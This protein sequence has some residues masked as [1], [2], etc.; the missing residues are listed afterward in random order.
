MRSLI[1]TLLAVSTLLI[2]CLTSANARVRNDGG[3][4]PAT[5]RH[6]INPFWF[7]DDIKPTRKFARKFQRRHHQR[8]DSHRSTR[9]RHASGGDSRTAT[10]VEHPAG[11]PSRSFCGCGA[12]IEVFGRNIRELWLAANWFKFPPASPAPGMVAVRRHHV[13]VIREVLS[14]GR[15]LAYDANSGGHRTRIWIRSLAG[16]SVRNPRGGSHDYARA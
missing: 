2:C 13:F 14:G 15:V 4:Q 5:D 12:S 16:F 10:F 3:L 1:A 8:A 7:Q 11:C 6:S 9:V